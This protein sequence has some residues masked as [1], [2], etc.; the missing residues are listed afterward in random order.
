MMHFPIAQMALGI[1]NYHRA[2]SVPRSKKKCLIPFVSWQCELTWVTLRLTW[3]TEVLASEIAYR[4]DWGTLEAGAPQSLLFVTLCSGSPP[5]ERS[6][7]SCRFGMNKLVLGNIL[8]RPLRTAISIVAIA[9]E[10]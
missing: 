5:G 10:V 8:Y 9:I 7:R 1:T 4:R 3:V 2:H 6:C